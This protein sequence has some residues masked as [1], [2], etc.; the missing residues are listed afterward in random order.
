VKEWTD[1]S[2][3]TPRLLQTI[4][5]TCRRIDNRERRANLTERQR[6]RIR[7]TTRVHQRR[8]RRRAGIPAR[9]GGGYV[10][11]GKH[12]S[13]VAVEPFADWIRE[14]MKTLTVSE[15]AMRTGLAERLI[16]SYLRGYDNAGKAYRKP[17]QRKLRQVDWVG[18]DTVDKALLAFGESWR[19][20]ELYPDN[21]YDEPMT[22]ELDV[23]TVEPLA[24]LAFA[25]LWDTLPSLLVTAKNIS[26]ATERGEGTVPDVIA[27]YERRELER[28][29]RRNGNW[30]RTGRSPAQIARQFG[31]TQG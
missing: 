14:K 5:H 9:K 25:K 19:L 26:S 16:Y 27:E 20:Q 8:L 18:I 2:K 29:K 30:R 17:K 21:P 3:M 11:A 6:Q 22:Y 13:S 1:K 23:I 15:V 28:A 7:H 12:G 10:K 4:C 31:N 24:D